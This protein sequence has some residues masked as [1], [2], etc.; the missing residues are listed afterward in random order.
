[1]KSC[2]WARAH[3][4]LPFKLEQQGWIAAEWKM[5]EN[6]RRANYYSLTRDGRK[7]LAR[8]FEREA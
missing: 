2:K 8:V 6:N 7:A 5:S 3:S 4:T 1:M